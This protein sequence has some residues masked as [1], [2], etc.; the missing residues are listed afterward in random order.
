MKPN[1][2]HL[3]LASM[4]IALVAAFMPAYARAEAPNAASEQSKWVVPIFL[5]DIS[6]IPE[7]NTDNWLD[8]AVLPNSDLPESAYHGFRLPYI[9]AVYTWHKSVIENLT[10]KC[11]VVLIDY[12]EATPADISARPIDSIVAIAIGGPQV[13]IVTTA[14]LAS[15]SNPA[16]ISADLMEFVAMAKAVGYM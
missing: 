10:A 8:L 2:I 16:L 11:S 6:A 15:G 9:N 7:L 4:F 5:T 13:R 14:V 3:V 1:H 12:K